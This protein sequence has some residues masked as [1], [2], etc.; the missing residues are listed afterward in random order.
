MLGSVNH[1][2][3]VK[4]AI[5][6]LWSFMRPPYPP[7]H[8][9]DEQYASYL[10]GCRVALVGPVPTVVGSKQHDLI[11]S[12]DRIVRLNHALPIPK[13]MVQDVGKRTDIWYHNFWHEHPRAI[14]PQDLSLIATATVDWLCCGGPYMNLDEHYHFRDRIDFYLPYL[15]NDFSFRTVSPRRYIWNAW[16]ASTHLNVGVSAILDLLAFNVRELY[17]TGFTFYMGSQSYH[18]GY[19]GVGSIFHRHDTQRELIIRLI[20]HDGR[21]HIDEGLRRILTC[22]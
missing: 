16:R 17:I 22:D 18:A 15:Q 5:R 20:R 19:P 6:T 13:I 9:S 11:E 4:R 12:F 14:S 3:K 2:E 21:I 10:S 1:P 7:S 8:T